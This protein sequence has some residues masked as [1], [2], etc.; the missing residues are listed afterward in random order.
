[1][2]NPV[3]EL[4]DNNSKDQLIE[5]AEEHGVSTDGNKD[6]IALRII[7]FEAG[8][9]DDTEQGDDVQVD[10][11]AEDMIN[12]DDLSDGEYLADEEGG[13]TVAS[14]EEDTADDDEE[15]E[16]SDDEVLVYFT[17]KSLR[18]ETQGYSFGRDNPFKA[19]PEK[20][21][22]AIFDGPNSDL[23]RTATPAQAREFYS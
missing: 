22:D 14:V 7:K 16:P 3:E 13:Q 20:D 2:A 9:P 10:P 6:D 12:T 8:V 1:M 19:V 18:F 11:E 17:G 15:D 5:L 23:F 21:A 4:V